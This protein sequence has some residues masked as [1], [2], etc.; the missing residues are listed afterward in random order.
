L[1]KQKCLNRVG[2]VFEKS[3]EE[4]QISKVGD[5]LPKR[6]SVSFASACV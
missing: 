3:L 2:I 5:Q 6:L 1:M 4:L